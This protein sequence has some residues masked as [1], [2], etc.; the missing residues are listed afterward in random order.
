MDKFLRILVAALF[1]V[2]ASAPILGQVAT[3]EASAAIVSAQD[4][5]VNTAPVLGVFEP[6][7]GIVM[8]VAAQLHSP[9]TSSLEILSVA[10]SDDVAATARSGV[11]SRGSFE[12]TTNTTTMSDD[13][14]TTSGS[15]GG[16]HFLTVDTVNG[17]TYYDYIGGAITTAG[18]LS[19]GGTTRY[20]KIDHGLGLES[21]T[22]TTEVGATLS[23]TRPLVEVVVIAVAGGPLDRLIN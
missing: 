16:K 23:G 6:D 20:Q 22:S 12:D 21:L 7:C 10:A 11:I 14:I 2:V 9:P 13:A 18:T 8:G 15:K 5:P 4:G 19:F 3:V 1:L 17:G